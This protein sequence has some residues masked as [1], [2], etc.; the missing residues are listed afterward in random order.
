LQVIYYCYHLN[1]NSTQ[2]GSHLSRLLKT[3][4]A[5]VV[6]NFRVVNSQR[7]YERISIVVI[8]FLLTVFR[9]TNSVKLVQK[10]TLEYLSRQLGR[11]F[12]K[13]EL[14]LYSFSITA[15]L[16]SNEAAGSVKIQ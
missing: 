10:L 12:N 7:R 1:N 6:K 8:A 3:S 13:Y 9:I 11:P 16:L 4:A 5:R 14:T 15:V 2:T